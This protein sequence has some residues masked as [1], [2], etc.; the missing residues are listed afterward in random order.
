MLTS[1]AIIAAPITYLPECVEWCLSSISQG[2]SP[3]FGDYKAGM[4]AYV[5][6][7]GAGPGYY[8]TANLGKL[9]IGLFLIRGMT[10]LVQKRSKVNLN[11]CS[12][13]T[14][15][16]CRGVRCGVCW[17]DMASDEETVLHRTCQHSWHT[18]CIEGLA[19]FEQGSKGYT[20]CPI[21]RKPM[22]QESNII[23]LLRSLPSGIDEREDRL[24]RLSSLACQANTIFATISLGVFLARSRSP[25]DQIKHPAFLIAVP[26]VIIS[27]A[28]FVA[29]TA[30]FL[31]Q[32]LLLR[33][34]RLLRPVPTSTRLLI[35]VGFLMALVTVG[36]QIE[37]PA[38]LTI[39]R[40]VALFVKA[41]LQ[42]GV[43]LN[44]NAPSVNWWAW[45]GQSYTF[46]SSAASAAL[47]VVLMFA[48][49]ALEFQYA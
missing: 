28:V 38:N 42:R 34:L 23:G 24:K 27:M 12:I 25:E 4:S 18:A 26:P 33:R 19:K 43:A 48:T 1:F 9:S 41:G 14:G 20:P 31:E 22:N 36:C 32:L 35:N 13:T 16:S 8:Y 44:P 37:V 47:V 3:L 10:R 5:A 46:Y 15:P 17:V 6:V 40:A 29:A 45:V 30:L 39:D 11:L 21:C 2:Y 49:G 7:L